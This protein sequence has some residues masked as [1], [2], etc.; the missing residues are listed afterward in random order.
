MHEGNILIIGASSALGIGFIRAHGSRYSNVFA[1]CHNKAGELAALANEVGLKL[2]IIASDLSTE[3]GTANLIAEVESSGL[4]IDA[5]AFFAAPRLHIQR[6]HKL[7]WQD[8]ARHVDVQARTAFLLM[9]S[10]LPG[11]ARR[12][13]GKLVFVLS[14]VLDGKP[15]QGMA[16]YVFGK[17][18]L[19]G[20]IKSAAVEYAG[21]CV[22]INAVSPSM[23]E[24]PFLNE[25][26]DALVEMN[27]EAHPRG[28]N[29]T[30]TEIIP[31]VRFLLSEEASF[32]TGQNI[33]A[34]GGA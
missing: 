22:C 3:P 29:A 1:H 12:R 27:A 16:D 21:K 24:T 28:T 9:Q 33:I 17:Y 7:N 13:Q 23:M 14:S 8:F 10:L 2:N 25:V 18:A 31:V 19:L 32:I 11:M 6:F 30:P 15:P 4:Q 5:V 26:P 34:T 20:L